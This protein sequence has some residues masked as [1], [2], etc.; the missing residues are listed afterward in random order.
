MLL[1][2]PPLKQRGRAKNM[3]DSLH[4]KGADRQVG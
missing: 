3:P 1:G 4:S 2:G